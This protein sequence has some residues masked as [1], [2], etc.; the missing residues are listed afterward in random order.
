[1]AKDPALLVYTK[2]FLEGTADLEPDE[3][4]VYCRLIFHQHQ[5]GVLPSEYKKLARLGGVSLSEFESI[6][7]S[8]KD[9]FITED[10]GIY[11]SRCRQEIAK[12]SLSA[13]K[14]SVKAVLGNFIKSDLILS[15]DEKNELK[16]SFNID[17]Y[18]DIVSDSERKEFIINDLKRE[19]A[20]RIAKRTH[21]ANGNANGNKDEIGNGDVDEIPKEDPEPEK[22]EY[23]KP[24]INE[25][26]LFLKEANNVN[27]L[28]GTVKENRNFCNL[29]IIRIA[30]DYPDHNPVESIKLL[31]TKAKESSFHGPNTTGFKYLY[32]HTQSII[33]SLA[34]DN[35]K[36]RSDP[37]NTIYERIINDFKNKHQSA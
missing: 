29:L 7:T 16:N 20:K 31:I 9:K 32:K 34:N 6:W 37:N 17:L 1:M 30:K 24:D 33:Q 26:I 3:M 11:N 15:K 27:S 8:L 22:T 5:R 14:N 19:H 23:G 35:S 28:D 12:R 4:G 2:D 18:V 13:R 25:L 36:K 21:K 10:L